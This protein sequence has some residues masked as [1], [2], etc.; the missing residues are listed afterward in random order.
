MGA[1]LT[2]E[3]QDGLSNPVLRVTA[4]KGT[5]YLR[6]GSGEVELSVD[7]AAEAV[8]MQLAADMGLAV[9]P[10]YVAPQNSLLLTRA[11]TG[12]QDDRSAL[13]E[14]LGTQLARLHGS[15]AAFQGNLD[16]ASVFARLRGRLSGGDTGNSEHL[17]SLAALF[18]DTGRLTASC[19][20]PSHG[21]LSPGNCLIADGRLWLIDWE[22]SAMAE[23]AWDLAYA[24]QENGFKAEA[25]ARFLSAYKA[26][27]GQ[28]PLPEDLDVMKR[29]SDAISALWALVQAA[30][31]RD[32]E[33][34]LFFARA[35]ITRALGRS[36][37]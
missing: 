15:G 25:E 27:G 13:P 3:R 17:D 12:V 33:T 21:D 5:F 20:V 4:E 18:A 29:R 9:V 24:I 22:Y 37:A 28:P 7:R 8:N 30:K 35:R 32:P 10:E 19:L 31:G 23:P 34:F 36:G 2:A 11:V 14:L 16:P 1:P 26:S 6:L